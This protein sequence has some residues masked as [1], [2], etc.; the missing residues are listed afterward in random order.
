ML[1]FRIW[2]SSYCKNRSYR[3]AEDIQWFPDD[4]FST[5]NDSNS[6]NGPKISR[7]IWRQIKKNQNSLNRIFNRE[8]SLDIDESY[9]L[10][11]PDVDRH[12]TKLPKIEPRRGANSSMFVHQDKEDLYYVSWENK[13]VESSWKRT[14]RYMKS[15]DRFRKSKNMTYGKQWHLNI[16][17]KPSN[18]KRLSPIGKYLNIKF[19]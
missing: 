9:S 11:S 17:I 5:L 6:K 12:E 7:L 3:K 8:R 15:E 18:N 10:A 13:R 19:K 4:F 16:N 1:Q 14:H 2:M